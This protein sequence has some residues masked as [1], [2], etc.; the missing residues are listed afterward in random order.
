VTSKSIERRRKSLLLFLLTDPRQN[1]EY[2]TNRYYK[3]DPTKY[4]QFQEYRRE[5]NSFWPSVSEMANPWTLICIGSGVAAAGAQYMF[6][7]SH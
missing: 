5:K 3:E 1:E 4:Q 2:Q 7:M 6:E